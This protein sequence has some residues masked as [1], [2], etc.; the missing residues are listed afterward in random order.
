VRRWHL[1]ELLIALAV[2]AMVPEEGLEP[3]RV[4]AR[5]ILSRMRLPVPPLRRRSKIV[6][7]EVA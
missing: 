6:S 7:V 1:V 3:S 5:A 4:L 2:P